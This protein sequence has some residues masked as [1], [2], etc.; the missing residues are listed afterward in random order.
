MIC[1]VKPITLKLQGPT[2][3]WKVKSMVIDLSCFI[4]C[5]VVVMAVCSIS[6]MQPSRM[7]SKPEGNERLWVTR[8]ITIASVKIAY[9]VQQ[10]SNPVSSPVCIPNVLLALLLLRELSDTSRRSLG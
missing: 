2:S 1:P 8:T 6:L 5:I 7:M 9:C 4:Y 3:I 10:A